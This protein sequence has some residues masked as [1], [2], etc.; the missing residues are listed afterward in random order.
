MSSRT[1]ALALSLCLIAAVRAS[2][3][4]YSGSA[5]YQYTAGDAGYR[6]T[7]IGAPPA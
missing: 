5:G 1:A 7:S 4:L 6:L 2:A 3:T